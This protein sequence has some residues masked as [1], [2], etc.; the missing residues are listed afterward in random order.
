MQIHLLD[1]KVA[2]ILYKTGDLVRLMK[3]GSFDFIGRKDTQVKINGYRIELGEIVQQI[4]ACEDVVQSCVLVV[5]DS[6]VL[7][8]N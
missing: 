3:D 5:N 8:L 6:L 4:D 7:M 2:P 1:A